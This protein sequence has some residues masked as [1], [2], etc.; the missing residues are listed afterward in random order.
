MSN[1]TNPA[2]TNSSGDLVDFAGPSGELSPKDT[3]Q[4]TNRQKI[5]VLMAHLGAQ[6]VA[7]VLKE[8]SDEEAILFSKEIISLPPVSS[9]MIVD[10]LAEFMERFDQP[11]FGGPGGLNLAREFLQERL[12]QAR[13]QEILDQIEGQQATGPFTGMLRV[14]P[15][16]ALSVLGAQQP[17][18]VAVLLAYLAPEDAA[19]LLSALEPNFRVKVAKRIAQLS[20]VDPVAVRQATTLLI[21]KLRNAEAAGSTTL[22]SGSVVMAEIL[23]HSD[24]TIEQQVLS[25]IEQEDQTLA[26]QIRAKLFT[27]DDVLALDDKALQQVFRRLDAPTLALAMR[28]PSLTAEALAKIRSNVSERVNAMIEEEREVMGA[29]RSSQIN[30]AQATIVRTVRQLDAEGVIVIARDND[31]EVVA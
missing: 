12:G 21:G 22:A 24:R 1:L 23:N 26:E 4:L 29:V 25:E 19:S 31:G 20:R 7:P 30:A 28:E 14:D 15:Q 5:A 18:V 11:D 13:A 6:R 16:Q 17:Q 8:M 10:I 2:E 9:R 27:F 3:V